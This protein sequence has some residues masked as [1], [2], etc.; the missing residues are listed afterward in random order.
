[1]ERGYRSIMAYLVFY[2]KGARIASIKKTEK[3]LTDLNSKLYLSLIQEDI[4]GTVHYNV[5]GIKK[6]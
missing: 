5:L 4:T 1:M 3:I 6:R 2:V